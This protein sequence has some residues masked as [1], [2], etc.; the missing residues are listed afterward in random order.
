MFP[1]RQSS[2][3][4]LQSQWGVQDSN[5]QQSWCSAGQESGNERLYTVTHR[6]RKNREYLATFPSELHCVRMHYSVANSWK[7]LP[8][9]FAIQRRRFDIPTGYH[10]HVIN[11]SI[12]PSK[13]TIF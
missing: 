11:Y 9:N 6:G 8:L 3:F 12:I 2:P 7:G 5:Q 4:R 1:V 10:R 13:V